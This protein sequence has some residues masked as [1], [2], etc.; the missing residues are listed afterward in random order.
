M[1]ELDISDPNIKNI[2]EAARTTVKVNKSWLHRLFF[3]I[4]CFEV[5]ERFVPR[6][7]VQA[8]F[9]ESTSQVKKNQ[10]GLWIEVSDET[11]CERITLSWANIEFW[12]EDC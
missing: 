9:F 12:F 8:G 5:E 10:P 11:I 3:E 6:L 2:V 1:F 7:L 4:N